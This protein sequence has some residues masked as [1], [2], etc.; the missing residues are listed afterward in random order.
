[1]FS[2]PTLSEIIQRV[3][4]DVLSRLT[5]DDILRRA[6]PEVLARVVAGVG[7]GLYGFIEWLSQ[8]LIYDTAEAEF[9]ER[10]ASIWGVSRKPAAA[11]TGTVTFT[12][13]AGAVIASGTLL[14]ALDG[15]QYETTAD[16]TV[17]A[18]TATAP[19]AAL[20]AAAAG[21]RVT[22]QG[23]TLV[24][25]VVG[26]QS[27]AVAGELSGGADIE[28]DDALRARLLARIQQPPHGGADFDYVAW[29]LEVP[30]VTRAWLYAAELG[31]GT[32]TLRFVRD[33]DA[34][35]IPD[36]GEVATVQ[37]YIDARRPVTAAVT[38][39]APIAVPLNFTITGLTP[40]TA[41]VKE[42][43][44]DE[45]SDLLLRKAT[46]GGT[47]LLSHLRAAISSATGETDYVLT[48]PSANVTHTT[49]QMATMGTITW[50]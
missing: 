11:A 14:Q 16:A 25:P 39:A 34:S 43:V 31:L 46:P 23:V 8:Q 5:A 13:Q 36:A 21:N 38:V 37:A 7:H 17:T 15:V 49:G 29:A 50:A 1:M 18:P 41:A 27:A 10:W 12:V 22:G 48:T 30:G 24:S 47:I 35:I 45:L 6:D 42:A 26:V 33:N 19:V 28:T 9:L 3:R 20:I 4:N 2:R 44:E 32:V 40:D